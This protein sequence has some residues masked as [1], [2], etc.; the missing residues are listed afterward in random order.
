MANFFPALSVLQQQVSKL[1]AVKIPAR[2][3]EFS[4]PT[5]ALY[6]TFVMMRAFP[7][8]RKHCSNL[9]L[10]AIY[11]QSV[12]QALFP[13]KNNQIN[14]TTMLFA[15]NTA[16]WRHKVLLLFPFGNV[17]RSLDYIFVFNQSK[18]EIK[19]QEDF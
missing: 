8:F 3:K 17:F 13:R 19:F 5:L 10:T 1:L 16:F 14:L 12:L 6:S 4:A 18:N 9:C 15:Q 2:K 11:S 7:S